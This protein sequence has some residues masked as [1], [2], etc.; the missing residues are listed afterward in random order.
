MLLVLGLENVGLAHGIE[1]RVGGG[2]NLKEVVLEF[3][4]TVL[5]AN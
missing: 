5:Q 1:R 4:S 3:K 2:L